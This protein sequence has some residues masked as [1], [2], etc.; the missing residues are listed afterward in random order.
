MDSGSLQQPNLVELN[1]GTD[2]TIY[3]QLFQP[4]CDDPFDLTNCTALAARFPGAN[5]GPPVVKTLGAGVTIDSPILGKGHINVT[6]ADTGP[7]SMAQ[8]NGLN[9]QMNGTVNALNFKALFPQ[10]LN[11]NADLV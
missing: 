5:G 11:V 3:F 4:D 7:T 8:G 10:G 2:D 6:A 1:A 9:W